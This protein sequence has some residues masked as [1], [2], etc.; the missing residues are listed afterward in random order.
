[1]AEVS[2]TG[3]TGLDANAPLRGHCQLSENVFT[4]TVKPLIL[5]LVLIFLIGV[6][7][8]PF[9][10]LYAFLFFA[11]GGGWALTTEDCHFVIGPIGYAMV[12]F[13]LVGLCGVFAKIRR[14]R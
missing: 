4:T 13:P 6:F 8:L 5:N 7:S 11:I 9:L 10:A 3:P 12:I 2:S 14:D 1:M